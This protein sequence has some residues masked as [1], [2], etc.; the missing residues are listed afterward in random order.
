MTSVFHIYHVPVQNPHRKPTIP[1]TAYK[2]LLQQ[3]RILD[4]KQLIK[5]GKANHLNFLSAIIRSPS[6]LSPNTM[7]RPIP[8]A[9]SPLN[10]LMCHNRIAHEPPVAALCACCS[11]TAPERKQRR[12][13]HRLPRK[14]SRRVRLRTCR[15]FRQ[16]IRY[17][18][19]ARARVPGFQ[20]DDASGERDNASCR[21]DGTATASRSWR[22]I[23][24]AGAIDWRVTRGWARVELDFSICRGARI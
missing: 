6:T 11:I 20:G 4:P 2:S 10:D 3:R 17:S 24:L 21:G 23:N 8:C 9:N 16:Y 7:E 1:S 13:A 22:I 5:H 14:I 18:I 19:H 15:P 12:V